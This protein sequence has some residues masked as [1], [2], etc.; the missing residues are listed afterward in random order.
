[1]AMKE[2][3]MRQISFTR[4]W[5][6]VLLCLLQCVLLSSGIFHVTPAIKAYAESVLPAT[7]YDDNGPVVIPVVTVQ[8]NGSITY[9]VTNLDGA[10]IAKGQAL[11]TAGRAFVTPPAE[12]DGYYVLHVVDNTV[13]LPATQ[14][15]PYAILAPFRAASAS[16]FGVSAHF[17]R[18]DDLSLV[19]VAAMLGVSMVR[20][21]ATWAQI[22]KVAGQYSFAGL[23]PS[24]SALQ[25]NG[26][27]PLLILDY[28]NPLY[29]NNKTPYDK[30]G[31]TAFA[32]Y[33]RAV[34]TRY[35]TQLKAVEVYNEYNG[36]FSN[37]PCTRKA[38]C[39]VQLLQAT[40]RAIKAVRS[41]VTVVGGA[42][43]A[44]DLT[45][46]RQLFQQKALDYMDAV[47][48][49]PYTTDMLFS[50]EMEDT[51]KQLQNLQKLIKSSNGGTTKPLWVT[52]MGWPTSL[53]HVDERTQADYLVRSAVLCLA[54]GVHKYFWY[55]LLN[56]GTD[57]LTDSD[58]FGL[59][60][61]PDQSGLY[62]PKP[63]YVAYAVLIRQLANQQFVGSESVGAGVYDEH[64]SSNLRVLWSIYGKSSI[65]IRTATPLTVTN[66]TGG[67]RTYKPSQGQVM[68]QLSGDPIYLHG[69]VQS[70]RLA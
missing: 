10:T 51:E 17:D 52:E 58:K 35:G 27:M 62:T 9:T 64:F 21:D 3:A 57:Q 70:I 69:A 5:S 68:L 49:H 7:V 45:W 6:I 63:A 32:N 67:T 61:Q 39:Y 40:Y 50:S 28:N 14:R 18:G 29:D 16:P 46:F 34:V 2:A 59:L 25:Q 20:E 47:S 41:N 19:P 11:V 24:M 37:G 15:I 56:D 36:T 13:S 55:D 12:P 4:R 42:V 54:A 60:R 30:A 26:L 33:A 44:V 66:M 22:E 31:F 38:S 65:I 23:D 48:V 1:M 53:L 43:F 8:A